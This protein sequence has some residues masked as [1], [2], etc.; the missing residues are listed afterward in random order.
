[1]IEKVVEYRVEVPHPLESEVAARIVRRLVAHPAL[2]LEGLGFQ[3]E[4]RTTVVIVRQPTGP[5]RR[6]YVDVVD[7][8][9]SAVES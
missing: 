9:S 3:Q 7:M 1:M 8:I 2:L 5:A 4:G 6:S